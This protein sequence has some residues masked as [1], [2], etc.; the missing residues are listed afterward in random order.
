[1][2]PYTTPGT[3][4]P[5]ATAKEKAA[6][7]L[8]RR[9]RLAKAEGELSA[10]DAEFNKWLQQTN[11]LESGK[12]KPKVWIDDA[13]GGGAEWSYRTTEP[14]SD[15]K[16]TG[17]RPTGWSESRGSFGPPGTPGGVMG[18]NGELRISGW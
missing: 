10:M 1:V 11:Q 8:S 17:F 3:I 18:L 16:E 4:V 5:W 13:Q 12:G 9:Q 6:F 7:E 2:K 15:W 14:E